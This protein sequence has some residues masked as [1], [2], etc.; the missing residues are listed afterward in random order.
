MGGGGGAPPSPGA[1]PPVRYKLGDFGQATRLDGRSPVAVDEG[2]CRCGG[3][4]HCAAAAGMQRRAEHRAARGL[5]PLLMQASCICPRSSGC[6]ATL[7]AF[8]CPP[9]CPAPPPLQVHASGAAAGRPAP[10]GCGRHVFAG[11]HAAGAGHA[12]GAACG[13]AA[14]CRPARGAAAAAAHLHAALCRDDQVRL[15]ACLPAKRGRRTGAC[16]GCLPTGGA[17][18]GQLSWCNH[19]PACRCVPCRSLMAPKPEDRPSAEKLLASPL[20]ALHAQQAAPAAAAPSQGPAT[21]APAPAP[22]AAGPAAGS[23]QFGGLVLSKSTAR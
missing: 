9:A 13:G 10:P 5:P 11:R 21:A 14:V 6:K 12:H 3:A 4:A 1:A 18:A 23:K 16:W 2:D 22:A 20:L 17:G 19:T 8:T 7:L 15:Q